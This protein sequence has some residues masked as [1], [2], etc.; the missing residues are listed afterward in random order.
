MEN[1]S[2]FIHHDALVETDRIG[3]GT[4][5][6]RNAHVMPEVSIGKNCNIG[7]N[8]FIEENVT[9][10]SGVTVKNNVALWSNITLEDDVFV[11]PAAVFTNDLRPRAFNKKAKEDLIHTRIKRGATVGANATIVC[12]ITVHEYAFIGAGSVVTREVKPYHQVFGNP[13]RFHSLICR[14]S[15]P[16]PAGKEEYT[17]CCGLRYII[18]GYE[19]VDVILTK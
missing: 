19:I 5:I 8:C 15:K 9:I 1:S 2:V 17:C 18:R 16:I 7:E 10:G 14:C 13:A 6:W 4:R 11:G 3:T 12:G